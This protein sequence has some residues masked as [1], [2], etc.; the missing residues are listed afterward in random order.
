MLTTLPSMLRYKLKAHFSDNP[1]TLEALKKLI[2][3]YDSNTIWI[4]IRIQDNYTLLFVNFNLM[5][6]PTD[7][8]AHITAFL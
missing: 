6:L 3:R 8:I 1:L 4:K 2:P 7:V 5:K